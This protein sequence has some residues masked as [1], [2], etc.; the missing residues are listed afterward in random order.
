MGG[1]LD[2]GACGAAGTHGLTQDSKYEVQENK[3]ETQRGVKQYT[4]LITTYTY[5]IT[6][7]TYLEI[8]ELLEKLLRGARQRQ[9][10]FLTL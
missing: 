1:N 4:Y 7:S 9:D 8:L 5:L 6:T 10:L 2:I 3:I